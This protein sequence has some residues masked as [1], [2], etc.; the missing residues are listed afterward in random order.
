VL[1]DGRPEEAYTYQ[2]AARPVVAC[3]LAYDVVPAR[4][5]EVLEGLEK[6]GT[7]AHRAIHE[8]RLIYKARG[9][10][11]PSNCVRGQ[12]MMRQRY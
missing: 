1:P 6:P 8:G 9:I 4:W 3:G 5:S 11:L 10:E 7:L 2:A 12:S